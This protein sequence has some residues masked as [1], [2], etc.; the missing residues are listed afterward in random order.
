M[1]PEEGQVAIMNSLLDRLRKLIPA[2]QAILLLA[3]RGLGT[4]P[5]WQE[6]LS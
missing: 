5:T 4:S 6:H 1:Y 2:D 3:D